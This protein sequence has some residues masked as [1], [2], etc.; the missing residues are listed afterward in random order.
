MPSRTLIHTKL[1]RPPTT[2][3]VVGRAELYER[4]E[5][6]R[7]LP[8]TLVS[9]PAG[10]GKTTLVGHWLESRP[11]PS[12]WLSLEETENDPRTLLSYLVA[13]VRT[14]F[15]EACAETQ[16][17]LEAQV[18]LPL[19]DI[20][21][22]LCNE[23]DDCET[24][25]V[26][27][28]DDYHRV[29]NPAVHDVLMGC[30]LEHMPRPLHLVI[31]SR[32]DPPLPLATLRAHH[33]LNEIRLKDLEFTER[34]A[35]IFLRQATGRSI[36]DS[37]VARIY[38]HVEGWAVGLRL[39]ALALQHHEDADA[40]LQ[41]FDGDS[42]HMREYLLQE[43]V[44]RQ[45]PNL[46]EW[47]R[48]TS[49]LNRFCAP[50]CDAVLMTGDQE[51]G[52]AFIRF[53]EDRGMLCVSL[54]E[55]QE[56]FRYHH[57]FQELLYDQLRAHVAPNEIASLHQRAASWFEEHGWLEEAIHHALAGEGPAEAA[58]LIVRH[59]NE[60]LNQEQ[61]HRL[62]GWL[63]RL[64]AEVIQK[65]PELLMLEAW[66]C[67][68]RGRYPQAYALLDGIDELLADGKCEGCDTERLR[69]G[70]NALRGRQRY[71]EG[72][73]D[74]AMQHIEL[75]LKQLPHDCLAERGYTL[76]HVGA[77]LQMCGELEQARER[78]YAQLADT[79]IPT[80][81]FQ[82]RLLIILSFM[83]WIA[84][85]LVALQLTAHQLFALGEEHGLVE[86][87]QF[88]RYFSGIAEYQRNEL[89]KAEASLT[90]VVADL[91][92]PNLEFFVESAF[93]LA[94]VY[95]ATGQAEKARETVDSVCQR[96]L[97]ARNSA[98]LQRAQAYQADLAVRQG[99]L[100]EA[101]R[102]A[103]GFNPEPFRAT[104]EFFEPRIALARVLIA[105][106]SADSRVQADSL[107]TRLETF[108][109]GIHATRVLIEVLAL[110]ALLHHAQGD[111]PAACEA[112]GRAVS[113]AQPGGFIRLF[114]DLGPGLI[115][116]LTSLE[117]EEEG[118]RY[119]GRILAAFQADRESQAGEP[120][121]Q[122]T[123]Q[124]SAAMTNRELEILGLLADRLSRQEIADRLCISTATVKRHAENIYS[125]LGVPG[126]RQAVAKARDLGI[127]SHPRAAGT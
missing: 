11:G 77:A 116:V 71:D 105:Q 24:E 49:I 120:L 109:G 3:D 127:L 66:H 126:R 2:K 5:E 95:Q 6:G 47:M 68:N 33:M 81:T 48:R 70:V 59:R 100:S 42:Q 72:H 27:A 37:T 14:I 32:M 36:S 7:H 54:D 1:Y 91:N 56:W 106:S 53:L 61:W 64:P 102:W 88:G 122:R 82:G 60:I 18:Q 51:A 52:P 99:R 123:T 103:E 79:S 58:R 15:P 84:G 80:G 29:D 21:V 75:A 86:S 108:V 55:K 113:L 93:A 65:D 92:V 107:L 89:A 44:S 94:S 40:F 96:V 98:L 38:D 85:D 23:L 73:G 4:L 63:K 83:N 112:L 13:A 22:C 30:L 124:M 101:V 41:E 25:F 28:L 12:A 125:K 97:R 57:L 16:A 114:V 121:E 10:Y 19:A 110:R 31:I 35:G 20:A 67:Q 87:I 104:Y 115:K 34:E 8:L 50:V 90:P 46:R 43:V 78:L 62:D 17:Q 26:L 117:L 118:Q 9:A 76:I 119:V 74:L 39:A 45:P 69:G 111:E